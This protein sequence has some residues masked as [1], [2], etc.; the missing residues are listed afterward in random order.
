[1]LSNLSFFIKIIDLLNILKLKNIFQ[2]FLQRTDTSEVIDPCDEGCPDVNPPPQYEITY[3]DEMQLS[4]H[5]LREVPI[6]SR[7]LI[8]RFLKNFTLLTPIFDS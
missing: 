3:T 6:G 8:L 1:M 5:D 7:S 4:I 2:A